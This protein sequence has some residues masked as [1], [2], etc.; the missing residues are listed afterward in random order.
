MSQS[1]PATST[2]PI[3]PIAPPI[4]RPTQIPWRLATVVRSA[5]GKALVDATRDGLVV[6][7][8]HSARSSGTS[9]ALTSQAIPADS[10]DWIA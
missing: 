8:R 4:K 5:R 10:H 2:T 9:W 3:A 6:L 7:Q 1:P